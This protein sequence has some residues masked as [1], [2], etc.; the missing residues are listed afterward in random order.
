MGKSLLVQTDPRDAL[1]HDDRTVHNTRRIDAQCDKLATVKL[2]RQ[3]TIAAIDAPRQILVSESTVGTKFATKLPAVLELPQFP[4]NYSVRYSVG[5][6][7]PSCQKQLDL[8][9][10]VARNSDL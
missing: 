5:R 8:S 3:T 10:R 9:G 7:K 6:R 2:N 1:H 4:Q